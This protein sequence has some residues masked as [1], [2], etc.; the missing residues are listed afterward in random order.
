MSEN[1]TVVDFV[2]DYLRANPDFFMRHPDLFLHLR[3]PGQAPD[4]SR[5]PAE[6]QNEALKGALSACQI[7]EEEQ[8]LR[9]SLL[10]SDEKR[11]LMDC[12]V[13]GLLKPTSPS[14]LLLNA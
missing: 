8:K 11:P 14:S 6:C 2:I 1:P 5:S 7:R 9:D 13:F 3:V 12:F 4:G 10:D